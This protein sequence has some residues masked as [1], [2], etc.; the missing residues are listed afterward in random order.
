MMSTEW[1]SIQKACVRVSSAEDASLAEKGIGIKEG[2]K[3]KSR[4]NTKRLQ[5]IIEG[6]VT[7]PTK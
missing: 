3:F 2:E 7:S 1:L 4:R 6:V 5:H